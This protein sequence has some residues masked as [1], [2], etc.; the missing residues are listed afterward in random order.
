MAHEQE[1]ALGPDSYHILTNAGAIWWASA[2]NQKVEQ[3]ITE[4][5]KD[6]KEGA[7][8]NL[9]QWARIGQLEN[10]VRESTTSSE[11]TSAILGRVEKDIDTLYDAIQENNK[12]LRE[13]LK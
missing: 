4:V 13:V 6:A 8:E 10:S 9:R 7:D 12:L 3:V 1:C 2:I 5:T 11:V